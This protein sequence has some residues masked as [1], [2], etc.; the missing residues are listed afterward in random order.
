MSGC[1]LCQGV[2]LK[3]ASLMILC[4]IHLRGIRSLLIEGM[5]LHHGYAVKKQSHPYG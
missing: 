4:V 2:R 1:R 3:N 5:S